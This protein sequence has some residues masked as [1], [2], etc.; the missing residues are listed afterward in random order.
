MKLLEKLCIKVN[1]EF[2]YESPKCLVHIYV[3]EHKFL[4]LFLVNQEVSFKVI[5]CEEPEELR[6]VL[7]NIVNFIKHT[8]PVVIN[9]GSLITPQG[10]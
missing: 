1:R 5:R 7:A 4:G 9:I 3:I 2:T 10:Q 6:Q 8:K